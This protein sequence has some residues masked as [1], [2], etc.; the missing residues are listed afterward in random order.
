MNILFITPYLPYPLTEGGRISQFAVIDSLRAKN[1]IILAAPVYS[2]RDEINQKKLELIWPEVIFEPIDLKLQP[3]QKFEKSLK[4]FAKI[5]FRDTVG[6][7][8]YVIHLGK[9]LWGSFTETVN[10][11]R[12]Q[13][14]VEYSDMY[15]SRLLQFA[16]IK[17]KRFANQLLNIFNKHSVEIIQIDLIEF[18][19]LALLLPRNIK[20]VFVHHEI[21]YACL[22]S[23]L[24]TFVSELG[25]YEK[26]LLDFVRIRELSIL[27]HYDG[28][29]V[30]SEDDRQ[31]L[32]AD[33]S[34]KLVF[35]I[36]FPVLDNQ[37]TDIQESRIQ[38]NK[39]VFVGGEGHE[40]NK[41][42]IEWYANEICKDVSERYNL[43]LHVIGNWK[44]KTIRKFRNQKSISFVGVIE[45]LAR[46]CED[47]IMIVPIRVGSGI[48]TKILYAMANAVP[49]I[50]TTLG[51]EGINAGNGKEILISDTPG[52]FTEAVGRLLSRPELTLSMVKD[53]QLLIRNRYSQQ[54]NAEL[55][56][57]CYNQIL[58]LNRVL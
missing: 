48:R 1:K 42:A 16:A 31:R 18:V 24:H 41:D 23:A 38:I 39:L 5:F 34:G 28:I 56:L 29:F 55:R 4:L 35:N 26:Y 44:K 46:Y 52:E 33:F 20:K 45:D 6:L 58:K 51:C 17:D 49:V 22:E 53:A 36:P 32:L 21:R 10:N 50:S 19:D 14:I 30:F 15:S 12:Q 57:D 27:K 13:R 47:S 54:V 3:V 25:A 8:K 2:D 9:T 11:N 40:P 7:L 37:F 43:R